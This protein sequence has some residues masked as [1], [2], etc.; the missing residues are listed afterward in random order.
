MD[1]SDISYTHILRRA[2]EDDPAITEL[3]IDPSLFEHTIQTGRDFIST[4]YYSSL[5]RIFQS[6]TN[7]S[8]VTLTW[9]FIAL[10]SAPSRSRL[11]ADLG[12]K[13][14]LREVY[15]IKGKD[16]G[17]AERDWNTLM[18]DIVIGLLERAT[19]LE[20]LLI[21][22]NGMLILDSV[23]NS[24]RLAQALSPGLK[25]FSVGNLRLP[26][27]IRMN[28]ILDSLLLRLGTL[29]E[30]REVSLCVSVRLRPYLMIAA[31]SVGAFR[32]FL[33]ES[34]LQVL[35]LKNMGLRVEHVQILREIVM[36]NGWPRAIDLSDNRCLR[37]QGVAECL[38]IVQESSS[39]QV[40]ARACG[41]VFTSPYNLEIIF[42]A[43][44]AGCRSLK[45]KSQWI[46]A[47]QEISRSSVEESGEYDVQLSTLFYAIR[48]H[49]HFCTVTK[50]DDDSMI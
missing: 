45:K 4:S 50:S 21:D 14:N 5:L 23:R 16:E 6:N 27:E 3:L 35:E 32:T 11:G 13:T 20:K 8:K 28:D 34:N 48:E 25:V 18:I 38:R 15:I 24:E 10:F 29:P 49:P 17:L 7:I 44:K 19:S 33:E 12:Q 47:L 1:D 36:A 9:D 43:N 37:D 39:V 2:E 40:K 46:R 31:I 26:L 42:I 22:E 30:L 41:E